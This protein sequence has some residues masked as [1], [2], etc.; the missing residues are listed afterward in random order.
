MADADSRPSGRFYDRGNKRKRRYDSR[1]D[2]WDDRRDRDAHRPQ[3]RRMHEEPITAKLRRSLLTIAES[4]ARDAQDDVRDIARLVSDNFEEEEVR[5]SFVHLVLQLVLEQ[6]FKIPFVA[7]AIL[8][9][10]DTK[11]ELAKEVL[12][13]A[14]KQA[15][16]HLEAGNWRSF[17]LLLR[18]F[19]CQQSLFEGDGVFSVLDDLFSTAVDLQAAS[20]EDTVGIELVKIILLTIPYILASPAKGLEQ[21]AQELLEKTGIVASVESP[22]ATFVEPYSGE[23]SDKPFGYQSVIGLLQKQLENEA[24]RGWELACIPRVYKPAARKTE[25]DAE[26]PPEPT[27]HALP[28]LTVPSPVNPGPKPLFPESYFSLY[29]DQDVETVPKTSDIAACLL[30]DSLVDTINILDFNRNACSKFLL[31]MDCYWAPDTFIKRA[32]PFDKLKDVTGDQSTWKPEDLAVDAVFSQIL[33]LP[34]AEHKLVYYHSLITESC[35]LAPAAI[36]PSLGRGIRFLFRHLDS[37]DM[38]LAYRFMDWF[39]HHLSNFEFRWKWAE[40]TDDAF[41][42]DLHPKKAFINGALDKEIRLS[43][44]KRIRETLPADWPDL[45]NE[46]KDKDTPDFK[47]DSDQTPYSQEGKALLQLLRKRESEDQIQEVINSIHEKAGNLGVADVLIPSTDAYVTCICAI[48]SKSLSHVLSCIERCKERLLN[49]GP[50][51]EA[52][53]KQ[54]VTSVVEYWKDQPGVAVNIVDK[55]LNYTILSPMC[56][57]EWALRD[58][59]AAGQS[60]SESWVFEMV[61]G[62]VGKVTNRVRQIVAAKLQKG[63]P[64]DQVAMLDETLVKERDAM[65][66]LFQ[67]IDDAVNGVATGAADAF[68]EADGSRDMDDDKAKLVKAWGARWA[69]VFRRK[70][71]IEEAVVGEAAVEAKTAALAAQ[72]AADEAAAAAVQ[73]VV[74]ADA[75]DGANGAAEAVDNDMVVAETAAA[76]AA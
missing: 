25:D 36:A 28:A 42:S 43:F 55:L 44:A 32:T 49:I 60:L 35:K 40:W 24:A 16:T 67:V 27:K 57:V 61:A 2:D 51:S 62:T 30:R 13:A 6:P 50:Q 64:A 33:T 63:L 65:R 74:V 19:A 59:L 11:P 45:I 3:R 56:V 5:T 15:Q 69:R 34:S 9:A 21:N 41:T 70:G 12:G 14:Q 23:D 20:A 22:L 52:A 48:G 17:K 39:S 76:A 7:A 38:E 10:N 54:I 26:E 37:M 75:T 47:Y 18:F 58:R 8:Y 31:E 29:A 46:A 71:A 68:I 1:D 72:V 73:D 4:P 66:Q 53:R